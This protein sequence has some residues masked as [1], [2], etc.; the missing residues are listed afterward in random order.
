MEEKRRKDQG[1]PMLIIMKEKEKSV[2]D[3]EMEQPLRME[4][5]EE[6]VMYWKPIKKHVV[7][8]TAG[9]SRKTKAGIS[10]VENFSGVDRTSLIG[11][12][13]SLVGSFWSRW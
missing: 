12:G 1:I 8:Y 2:K 4:E 6:I 10:N 11:E 7:N 5:S 13:K 3:T 9:R